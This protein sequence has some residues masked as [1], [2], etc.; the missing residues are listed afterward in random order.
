[1]DKKIKDWKSYLYNAI[2]YLATDTDK[3]CEMNDQEQLEWFEETIGITAEEL[4][5][6]GIDWFK[7]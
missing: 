1:M 2:V 6:I 7:I 3:L 4:L 5:E